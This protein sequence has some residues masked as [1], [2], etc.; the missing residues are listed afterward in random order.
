[1]TKIDFKDC[2]SFVCI[3][4]L[5][6]KKTHIV[7]WKLDEPDAPRELWL[8]ITEDGHLPFH[9]DNAA[10]VIAALDEA[11]QSAEP[12][13]ARA[14]FYE[15]AGRLARAKFGPDAVFKNTNTAWWVVRGDVDPYRG[16]VLYRDPEPQGILER[17]RALPDYQDG[18]Q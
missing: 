15:T 12:R 16:E 3:D 4:E 8:T 2:G 9:G 7:S 11:M 1:M 5:R 17:L 14:R 10:E 18:G 6:I 13:D